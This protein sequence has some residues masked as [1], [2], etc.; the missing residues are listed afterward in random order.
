MMLFPWCWLRDLHER[1]VRRSN[2]LYMEVMFGVNEGLRGGVSVSDCHHPSQVLEVV[3]I[4]D[5][6]LWTRRWLWC[7]Y[8]VQHWDEWSLL[9]YIIYLTHFVSNIKKKDSTFVCNSSS[10]MFF[11]ETGKLITKHFTVVSRITL[12]CYRKDEAMTV[13]YVNHVCKY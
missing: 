4:P 5:P 10:E 2:L 3:V 8:T 13:Y 1:L 11:S 12:Q 9:I 6:H 7:L